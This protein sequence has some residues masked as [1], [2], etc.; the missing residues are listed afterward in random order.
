MPKT[1]SQLSTQNIYVDAI[2]ENVSHES[3]SQDS[4]SKESIS[5]ANPRRLKSV[6][7]ELDRLSKSFV[8]SYQTLEDQ[9]ERLNGQ[10]INETQLKQTAIQQ[11]QQLLVEKAAISDRLQNLL[12]IM[13]AG[14]VVIDGQGK[15]KDCNA[16][17]V[18]I[19]GRP[20]LGQLWLDVINRAF[21][22]QADD[23][24]QV[25]LKDGRKI[26]IETKALDAEPGQ[27]V[28]MTDLTK[29]RELQ[30]KLSQQQKL[31]SM[32]KMVASLAHQIRTPLSTAILYGSHLSD[33][34]LN[35][36]MKEKFSQNLMERLHFMERQI[37]DMLNFM[38]GERKQ[39]QM[40]SVKS[41]Y[42]KLVGL[43][44]SYRHLVDF[45][46]EDFQCETEGEQ[47]ILADEDSII[48]ALSNLIENALEACD[49]TEKAQISIRFLNS[50]NLKICISD[51]GKGISK[52][53][54]RKIFDPFYTDKKNGN[55]LGLSVVHGVVIDHFGSIQVESTVNV[56][57]QF[58]LSF[59][60]KNNAGQVTNL[61]PKTE[62]LHEV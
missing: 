60:L 34:N 49:K 21:C 20:L 24:H 29:T 55:G 36:Q 47:M 19:L 31:S 46:Y 26:H 37:D 7:S 14:V 59:P 44:E 4:A 48:G 16:M 6:L 25:S 32:G 54:Q 1:N 13:P 2:H 33:S 42:K 27:I 43:Y 45:H 28:V 3:A 8:N 50:E 41:L 39:K 38:K 51:N 18:D 5:P 22:P 11:N 61:H 62:K 12:A 10:L 9:V 23:G 17:A 56:G 53:K 57:T 35:Q 15:V 58:T 30:A 40:V 52:N